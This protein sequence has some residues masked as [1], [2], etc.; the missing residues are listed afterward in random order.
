[1]SVNAI[2][3]TSTAAATQNAA[4]KQLS[5]NFNTFLTLLTTQLKNQDPMSPMDSSQFTQ[6][7]VQFSQVEQSINTNDN[8][9]TL[10]SLTQGRSASDAV[11]YL[12]KTATITT[13]D[14]PL[15]NGNADWSYALGGAS[16]GTALTVTDASG[17]VV[18]AGQGETT[19]GQHDFAWDGKDS[20]GNQLPDGVYHLAVAGQA[21][22]GSAVQ[23][24]VA[25]SGTVSE[26]NLTGS[27]PLLMIGPMAV[28]L[29][30]IAAVDG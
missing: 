19:A 3:P 30:Q 5:G 12:G 7:L 28:P 27:E 8:L 20:N 10:I 21:A 24:S 4:T 13:G 1:M 15:S 16:T 11:S 9:K 22:D 29:S 25:S 14:A 23:T 6:Q 17:H 2:M 26:I 18:Y